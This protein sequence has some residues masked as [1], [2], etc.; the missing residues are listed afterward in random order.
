MRLVDIGSTFVLE[1]VGTQ[2]REYYVLIEP[3]VEYK[4]I[5]SGGS[6]RD[7]IAHRRVVHINVVDIDSKFERVSKDSDFGKHVY[8]A[9]LGSLIYW[10]DETGKNVP[11]RIVEIDNEK[12][13][14]SV[15]PVKK[16]EPKKE[17]QTPEP[18]KVINKSSE[19][20]RIKV[21]E[22]E[23]REYATALEI[24]REQVKNNQGL[25]V[26]WRPQWTHDFC[27]VVESFEWDKNELFFVGTCF[28]EGKVH[29]RNRRFLA[30]HEFKLYDGVYLSKIQF[31][32][33]YLPITIERKDFIELDEKYIKIKDELNNLIIEEIGED[34]FE[35]YKYLYLGMKKKILK[36]KYGID[37]KTP[38]ELNPNL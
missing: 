30:R 33:K 5:F 1:K 37:W 36:E 38:K 34:T 23:K 7:R 11:Y 29:Q 8:G 10:K 35:G 31:T 27:F 15:K 13:V 14:S 16:V 19:E 20:K 9:S 3:I 12:I 26:L 6:F 17:I 2:E 24:V 25:I 22:K 28:V 32:Y 4:P 18:K 21:S